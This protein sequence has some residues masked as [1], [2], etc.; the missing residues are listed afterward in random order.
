[1]EFVVLGIQDEVMSSAQTC[2][3]KLQN[4]LA[5]FPARVLWVD[6]QPRANDTTTTHDDR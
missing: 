4:A 1:M 6:L 3:L 2:N 5:D